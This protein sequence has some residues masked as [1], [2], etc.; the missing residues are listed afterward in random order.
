[1]LKMLETWRET[2]APLWLLIGC[3][4]S[5]IDMK[6]QSFTIILIGH[7]IFFMCVRHC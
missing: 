5:P 3:I 1:M 4:I 2:N 6:I 7:I